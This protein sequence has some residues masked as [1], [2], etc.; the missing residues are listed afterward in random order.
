MMKTVFIDLVLDNGDLVRIEAP[1]NVEDE[2]HDEL[3]NAMRRR[4][5]WAT[6]MFDGC[7][8][9]FMGMNLDRVNMGR[10]VGIL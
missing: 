10:V 6:R 8:A 9:K 4:D 3:N 7:R 5:W 2:L 1:S